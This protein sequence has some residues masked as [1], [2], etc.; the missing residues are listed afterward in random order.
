[1][2]LFD[3]IKMVFSS[4]F[5]SLITQFMTGQDYKIHG[6]EVSEGT[7]M[8]F[9]A[10]FACF[11]VLAETF[12]SVPIFEYKKLDNGDRE[13][14]DDTGL[15]DIL[16][17]M[18]NSEM[19]SYNWKEASMYQQ[20]AGGNAVSIR[21]INNYGDTRGLVP[22]EWQRVKI[23]RD[24][25]SLKLM[26]EV[27]GKKLFSRDQVFH[28]PGPS[29]NG[30]IGMSIIEFAA[31]ATQLGNSYESY[32]INFYKNGAMPS[33]IFKH[34]TVLKDEALKRLKE[35]L[36]Y[37]YQG[38]HNTG[39]PMLLEDDLD[40]KELSIK[41]ADAQFIECKKFQ[42][43]EICRFCRVPLHLVQN[44]DKATNNNIEHQSLEFIMYT[45][46]PHFKRAEECINTQLLSIEQRKKGYY[47]EFNMNT[48]LRGDAASTATAFATG[49]QWG[50]LSVNDIRRM[51][52][53]NRIPNGDIYLTPMNMIEAGKEPIVPGAI[54][55][56]QTE[57]QTET[58]VNP[59]VQEEI[60][61]LMKIARLK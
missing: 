26:Y 3:R 52:N 24:K 47:F 6:I 50:W 22:L 29:V 34:K 49:R 9:S 57:E 54:P 11:R 12:A 43:E 37:N 8:R 55:P 53:L 21:E 20:C 32:G 16:H 56:E 23:K 44:L 5:D 38:L 28:L 45:M 15:Y 27:D 2:K 36:K 31:Q 60:E 17:G 19:S 18:A 30:L 59:K 14:T 46:L 10:I 35:T 40:F 48:L 25:E 13:Q 33:G 42:V 1:M 51:L 41:P 39:T 4:D 61:D 7:S 58:T